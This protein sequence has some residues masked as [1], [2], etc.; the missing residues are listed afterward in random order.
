MVNYVLSRTFKSTVY[1]QDDVS[2]YAYA[3]DSLN[4]PKNNPIGA[5]VP[6]MDVVNRHVTVGTTTKTVDPLYIFRIDETITNLDN[7]RMYDGDIDISADTMLIMKVDGAYRK[8][9][10]HNNKWEYAYK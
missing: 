1:D 8:Y 9:T 6:L 3:G 4:P 7:F 10:F 5:F 2:L